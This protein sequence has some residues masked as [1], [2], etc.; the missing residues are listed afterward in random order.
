MSVA[1]R[2]TLQVV[3]ELAHRGP[4]AE[5]A[6]A[7]VEA[8]DAR[9]DQASSARLPRIGAELRVAEAPGSIVRIP[10]TDIYVSGSERIDAVSVQTRYGLTVTVEQRLADFGQTDAK[11]AAATRLR[12]AAV[13]D[14][15]ATGT[16]RDGLVAAAFFQWAAAQAVLDASRAETRSAAEAAREMRD[17]R[18]AGRQTPADV[19]DAVAAEARA[20]LA[21]SRAEADADT[22]RY[23]LEGLVGPL[24]ADAVP[25]AGVIAIGDADED[26]AGKA[27]AARADA[28]RAEARAISRSWRPV[29]SAELALGARGIDDSL[30][31]GWEAALVLRMPIWEPGVAPSA[32]EA[33]ARARALSAEAARHGQARQA[34]QRAAGAS[35]TAAERR[36]ALAASLVEHGRR[37]VERART[38]AAVGGDAEL[39]EK[40]QAALRQAE[41]EHTL[42]AIELASA[43]YRAGSTAGAPSP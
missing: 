10:D 38:R 26:A 28:A 34:E 21:M 42:A 36:V 11:V 25:D 13:L 15:R 12:D 31:P 19:D 17:L 30:F 35:V 4:G 6:S 20:Q 7:Q 29:L 24:P 2:I 23:Q 32:R 40:A 27:L 18:A 43:R 8:A 22:A 39:I 41:L 9:I 37:T 14:G 33:R 1:A 3:L 16:E 5:A